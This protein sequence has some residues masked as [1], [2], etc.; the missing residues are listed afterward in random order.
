[1]SYFFGGFSELYVHNSLDELTQMTLDSLIVCT[2]SNLKDWDD[3]RST[4]GKWETI[5][6]GLAQ[7]LKLV[8][9]TEVARPSQIL[10]GS[11]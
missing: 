3:T 6:E 11:L 10:S 7:C 1:M 8:M 4:V 5:T 2:P 9:K